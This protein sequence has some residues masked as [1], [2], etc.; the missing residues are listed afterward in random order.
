MAKPELLEPKEVEEIPVEEKEVKELTPE[1]EKLIR[2]SVDIEM[3]IIKEFPEKEKRE[4]VQK[5]A[6]DFRILFNADPKKFIELNQK[7]NKVFQELVNQT[8][9][10]KKEFIELHQKNPK[11]IRELLS[12]ISKFLES[13]SHD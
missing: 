6:S 10:E 8:L 2:Q 11:I 5:H 1:Q 9:E 3:E 12:Q 4:W 13:K 7:Y